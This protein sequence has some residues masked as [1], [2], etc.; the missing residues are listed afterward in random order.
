MLNILYTKERVYDSER[1]KDLMKGLIQVPCKKVKKG[2][3]SYQAVYRETREETGLHT[4]SKYL[5]KDDKF[6]CDIYITDITEGERP[7]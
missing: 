1:Y 4:V 2:K 5:I 6:N 3:T 7:Q